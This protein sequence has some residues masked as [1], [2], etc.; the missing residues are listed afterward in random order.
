MTALRRGRRCTSMPH[1]NPAWS[2]PSNQD[3]TSRPMICSCLALLDCN[4]TLSVADPINTYPA[5]TWAGFRVGTAGLLGVGL[6]LNV[7]ISTFNNGVATSDSKTFDA[8]LISANL[9]SDNIA[10]VGIPTTQPFD[11]IQI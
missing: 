3:C 7:T 10:D 8:G 6:G 1:S 11:E 4:A 9:L 2:S 5:G